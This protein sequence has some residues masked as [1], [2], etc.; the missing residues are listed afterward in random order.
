MDAVVPNTPP[1]HIPLDPPAWR[2]NSPLESPSHLL[3]EAENEIVKRKTNTQWVKACNLLSLLF[4]V[5]CVG[6]EV[7]MKFYIIELAAV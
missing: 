6:E 7:S 2:R 3:T 5:V 1:A 4:Q